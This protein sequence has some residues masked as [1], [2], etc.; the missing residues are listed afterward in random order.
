VSRLACEYRA[1]YMCECSCRQCP[2]GYHCGRHQ[3]D[4]HQT[5]RGV[6]Y[7]RAARGKFHKPLK[8]GDRVTIRGTIMEI[9]SETVIVETRHGLVAADPVVVRRFAAFAP[10]HIST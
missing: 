7:G 2:L 5:C 10:E 3:S 1:S 8:V 4:C 6:N 9:S